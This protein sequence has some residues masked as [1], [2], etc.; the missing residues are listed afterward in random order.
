MAAPAGPVIP[1]WDFLSEIVVWS[2][3]L[4]ALAAIAGGALTG[5]FAFAYTC[6][7]GA[8][9][10]GG[11]LAWMARRGRRELEAAG[12]SG[13]VTAIAFAGRLGLKAAILAAAFALPAWLD[14]RGAVAGVLVVDAA[15]LLVATVVTSARLVRVRAR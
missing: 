14:F 7:A 8:L 1:S 10:D 15:L 11:T 5:S 2:L 9:I 6:L 13:A 3:A 4:G 12:R